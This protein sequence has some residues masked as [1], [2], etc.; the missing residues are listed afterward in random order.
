[1][2]LDAAL[3]FSDEQAVTVT[4]ASAETP[5]D[6][7]AVDMGNGNP[8]TVAVSVG[9]TDF[10]GGTSMV[11][12]LQHCATVGGSYT[13]VL[14]TPAIITANLTAGTVIEMGTVP[15]ETLQFLRLNYTVSGTM[16]AGAINA[17]LKLGTN[18][19]NAGIV[20]P[21]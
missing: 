14:S 1:M 2:I 10:A 7:K 8:L 5:L 11:V 3:L 15:L 18:K 21:K 9:D 17:S 19:D 16:S 6:M 13:N 20:I 4:A 12:A